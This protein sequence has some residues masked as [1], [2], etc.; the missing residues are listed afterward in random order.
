L[1]RGC[2][3]PAVG[4]TPAGVL[5]AGSVFGALHIP[6]N[7]NVAFG[8]WAAAVGCAYG[9]LAVATHD[10]WAPMTAHVVSNLASAALWQSNQPASSNDA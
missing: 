10:L 6:G 9:T 4:M 5:V 3:L 7:R 1:F 8:L 2:L